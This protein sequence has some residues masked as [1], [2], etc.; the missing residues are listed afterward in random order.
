MSAKSAEN[1]ALSCP[2]IKKRI[3]FATIITIGFLLLGKVG[4]R[5][6]AHYFNIHIESFFHSMK[7]DIVHGLTF[8]QEREIQSA[9]R[10]YIPFYN[11]TR[12]HSSLNYVPPAAYERQLA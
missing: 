4:I 12:L 9:V 5:T 7:T 1:R 10:A 3:L 11:G 2:S 8:T 6:W